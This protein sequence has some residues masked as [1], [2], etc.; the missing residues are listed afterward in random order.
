MPALVAPQG[1]RGAAGKAH[2]E[3][4]FGEHINGAPRQLQTR[5]PCCRV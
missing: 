5:D 4:D 2:R 1:E 3:A